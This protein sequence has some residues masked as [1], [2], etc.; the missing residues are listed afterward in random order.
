M[1]RRGLRT[2][3]IHSVSGYADLARWVELR[4]EV[5]P[6]E[7]EDPERMA[8]VRAN[9]A[10]HLALLALDGEEPVGTGLLA[11]DRTSIDAKRP[12]AEVMV[13]PRH[14]R[15]GIGSTLLGALSQHARSLGKDGLTCNVRDEDERSREYMR[16]RGYVEY[17]RWQHVA[18]D[19]ERGASPAVDPPSGIELTTLLD[20]P[21]LVAG[22]WSVASAVYPELGGYVGR[23][24]QTLADWRVY[25]L[26]DPGIVLEASPVAVDGDSVVGFAIALDVGDGVTAR[27]RMTAVLPDWR[28][29]LSMPLTH[30]QIAATRNC[31]FRRLTAR[32]RSPD[33][34]DQFVRCGFVPL[35]TTIGLRGPL[36]D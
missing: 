34:H 27:H 30:A 17:T 4:N 15:R 5:E 28:Y 13:P 23:Q 35:R 36:V 31:G 3:E 18:L 7:P 11:G 19:L 14:R 26:G 10:D 2:I 16:R 20:R 21:D 32:V 12:F 24:A 1:S 33:L 25:E 9:E 6:D 22:M 29:R 8:L